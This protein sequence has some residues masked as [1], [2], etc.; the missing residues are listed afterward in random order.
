MAWASNGPGLT[1][2]HVR[3]AESRVA[4]WHEAGGSK[5]ARERR[6][7]RGWEA[8]VRNAIN[9]GWALQG[10]RGGTGRSVLYPE[11]DP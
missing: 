2:G 8:T 3:H 4:G 5:V 7:L 6:T 11:D 10:F 9:E 1:E